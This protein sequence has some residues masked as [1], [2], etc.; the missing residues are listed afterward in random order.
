MWQGCEE[1][2]VYALLSA[3]PIKEQIDLLLSNL[4]HGQQDKNSQPC[5]KI[6][7]KY[8]SIY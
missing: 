6:E 3:A 4:V 7:K 1:S 5:L 8:L 2:D